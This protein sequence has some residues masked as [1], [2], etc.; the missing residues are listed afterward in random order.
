LIVSFKH[1]Y[2]FVK[3]RKTAGTSVEIALSAHTGEDDI[4]TPLIAPDEIVRASN[5]HAR[6]PQNYCREKDVEEKY[7]ELIKTRDADSIQKY[8]ND[9]IK[10]LQIFKNHS[11][12]GEAHENL[13]PA[14]F[15]RAFKF[16][17]ERHPFEK[18]VSL[19]YYDRPNTRHADIERCIK[20]VIRDGSCNNTHFYTMDGKVVVDFFVRYENLREDILQL[21]KKIGAENLI[22]HLPFT[23]HEFR[24]DKRP[25]RAILS[26]AQMKQI[27]QICKN[28]FELFGYET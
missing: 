2:I 5:P 12:L 6:P 24:T 7:R 21:G 27:V 9:V 16:A 18:A 26:E 22:E 25:A 3:T 13:D 11:T 28:E 1:N 10:P 17:T 14:F 15:D 8:H 20:K 19:A 23:K 4:I